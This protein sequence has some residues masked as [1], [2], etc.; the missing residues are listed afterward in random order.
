MVNPSDSNQP[1]HSPPD[2]NAAAGEQPTPDQMLRQGIAAL[3]ARR[4]EEALAQFEA[5][6]QASPAHRTKAQMGKVQV[7]QKRGDV[8]LAR[9]HCQGLLTHA[10]PKVRQWAQKILAQLPTP[11]SASPEQV[12]IRHEA[13]QAPEVNADSP[14]RK[15]NSPQGTTGDK[16]GFIPLEPASPDASQQTSPALNPAKTD[17]I[18]KPS[19]ETRTGFT[20]L[21]TPLD[22]PLEK[23]ATP[24]ETQTG[25]IPLEDEAAPSIEEASLPADQTESPSAEPE[26]M[27]SLFH[28]QQ[29]NQQTE[30]GPD[31]LAANSPGDIAAPGVSAPSSAA[32]AAPPPPVQPPSTQPAVAPKNRRVRLPK[33]YRLWA[34]QALTAIGGLWLIHWG[35]HQSLQHVNDVIRFVFRWPF[36]LQGF[37][38]FERPHLGLVFIAGVA[39]MLASPWVLDRL[40]GGWYQQNRLSSRVLQ[41]HHTEV[42]R[43]LRRVCRQRQWQLPELRLIPSAVPICF[44]Y[45]WSPRTVRIVV[46]QGLLD[47][48]TD[49]ELSALYAYELAHVANWD[50]P[51]LSGLVVLLCLLYSGYWHLAR[52]GDDRQNAWLRWGSGVVASILYGLFWVLHKVGLWLSRLRG[53][54]CDRTALDLFPYPEQYQHLLLALTRQISA[55]MKQRGHLH[56]LL[57]SFDLLMPL[58][59][60]QAMSPGSFIEQ[61]TISRLVA[62]DCLNPYRY[63]LM[64]NNSHAILGERLLAFERWANQ[65]RIPALG[66]SLE[67]LT[68]FRKAPPLIPGITDGEGTDQVARP[69]QPSTIQD[70]IFQIGPLMGL[71]V[72][73]GIALGLWFL[74]GVVNRFNWQQVSWLYQDDSILQGGVLIGLG[75]GILMRVNRLFSERPPL[76]IDTPNL[77]AAFFRRPPTLPVNG[78]PVT[79]Q[80]TLIGDEGLANGLC[81]S[82]YL[83]KDQGM[84]ALQCTS[85]ADWWRGIKGSSHHPSAWMGRQVTVLGW[86]RR[87][88]GRLWLDVSSIQV[89]GH[90]VYRVHAPQ[91]TTG[92][93]LG[94]C[95]WGIWTIFTGG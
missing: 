59:P 91:W 79:L 92:L 60:R 72:G 56:P 54:Y 93:G 70:L 7:F 80:G 2:D 28:Y 73:G 13:T 29:L 37:R 49:E 83:L 89:S 58:S 82:L 9:Q 50:L 78:D 63:W 39:V 71:I 23:T 76:Q 8:L 3:K 12:T 77:E 1:A 64:A 33:P 45:G 55:D 32:A 40:L 68:G 38:V 18:P 31:T 75:M 84:L 22:T 48:L 4:Y 34:V 66:L 62:E 94:L 74:G 43:L 30:T 69:G 19:I 10:S 67:Q 57:G 46:S 11:E 51:V 42:L 26:A 52:W 14:T 35:L 25:F 95:A 6:E 44:S 81:Q 27:P 65:W 61:V 17:G 41:Q 53:D 16:T 87:A 21:D 47:T 24:P 20:P 88:G 86:L 90:P 36:Q 15:P 5:L 85:P